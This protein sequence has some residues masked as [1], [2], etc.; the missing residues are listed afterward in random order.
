MTTEEAKKFF[1]EQKEEGQTD[2]EILWTLYS[3]FQNDAIDLD[4]L[5]ALVDVLGYKL[6]DEFLSMSPEDQKTKGWGFEDNNAPIVKQSNKSEDKK[7]KVNIFEDEEWYEENPEFD[8][9]TDDLFL[10]DDD[11]HHGMTRE[12]ARDFLQKQRDEE[13]TDDEILAVLYS[14]FI[15]DVF[16]I[17]QLEVFVNLLGYE[18]TEEFKNMSPEDQKT[19]GWDDEAEEEIIEKNKIPSWLG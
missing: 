14:M 11:E 5:E 19:K 7:E 6:S 4:M 17:D 16:G 1:Q 15:D 8:D 9:I 13:H 10:D 3:M 18:L 2:N 12:E